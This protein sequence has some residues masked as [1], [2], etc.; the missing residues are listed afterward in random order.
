MRTTIVCAALA[1]SARALA[2][3]FEVYDQSASATAMAGAVSAKTDEPAAIFYNPAAIAMR[4]GGSV[5]AGTTLVVAS[6]SSRALAPPQLTTDTSGG[7]AALPT[8]FA[9]A[10][11]GPRLALGVGLF[12]PFGAKAQ[13]NALASDGK[14]A[15]PGRFL[16]TN[17]QLQTAVINPTVG[18]RASD[19]FAVAA[20]VDVMLASV[21]LSRAVQFA[22]V[23]G[24]A[25]LGG[26]ATGVGFNFGVLVELV[27]DRVTAGLAYRSA[28]GL[29]FNSLQAHFVAPPEL[30]AEVF[31]QTGRTSLRMPHTV[32]LGLQTK[33]RDDLSI[34]T[35]LHYARWS[36]FREISVTFPGSPTPG[37][38]ARQDWRDSVS[39]RVG[40]EWLAW[41]G[42][43]LRAGIGYDLT[44]I[45]S[46]T[47]APTVPTGDLLILSAGAGYTWRGFGLAAGYV[48]GLGTS[49]SSTN[50]DY[51]ATYSSLIQALSISLTYQ[52]S[53]NF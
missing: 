18:F 42:L 37:F 39:A 11:V 50:P 4:D 23:E 47:L 36:E 13:W 34:T 28:I 49:R 16:A 31:D 6:F 15:F 41:R 30:R 19:R 3:G 32:T 43:A 9:S 53:R 25:Q 46:S 8:V 40:A 52:W 22:D 5:L 7:F 35:D 1:F 38:A 20:G 44:P 21:E 14:S 33:P 12:A 10:H 24:S 48:I 51:L 26:T 29:D 17:T 27:P 45:P 2:G